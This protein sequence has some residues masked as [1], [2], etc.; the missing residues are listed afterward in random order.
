[1]L[2]NDLQTHLEHAVHRAFPEATLPVVLEYPRESAHGDYAC[3]IALQLAKSLQKNPREVA[4]TI[5]D[6]FEKP[7]FIESIELAGPGFLN[8]KV[9]STYLVREIQAILHAKETYGKNRSGEGKTVMIE[10]SS[11]N[12]N[13]PLHLGH[14]RN[15]FLGMACARLLEANGYRVIKT[16]I[17]NDRGI[18]ICKSMLAYQR[19]GNDATPEANGKKGDHFVGD[20]YVQY[21]KA[22]EEDRSLE[23]DAKTMLRRWEQGDPDIRALWRRMNDWV[24]NGF[25][26]TYGAIGSEFDQITFESDVSEGGR[27]LVEQALSEGKLERLEGGAIAIDLS[28]EGLGDL[29][30]GKKILI[31]SD[32]TTIYMTQDLQLAVQRMEGTDLDQLIYVVGNEQDY[33]FKVLFTVLERLGYEWAKQCHHLSYGMVDLPGGKMKSREGTAVDIDT[34]LEELETLVDA[35][36]DK[37]LLDYPKEERRLLIRQIAL[38]ALKYYLLKVDARSRILYDPASS[39]DFQGDTG[40]YLQ[41]THARLCSILRKAGEMEGDATLSK[42]YFQEEEALALLRKLRFFPEGVQNALDDYRLHSIAT[43]LHELAQLMNHFYAKYPVLEAPNE[44]LRKARLALVMAVAQVLRNGL[45]LLGIEPVE[46][47]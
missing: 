47:M 6:V 39:I 16:Q 44:R 41:Y 8:F 1:M 2:K 14:A 36:I 28:K 10:Y 34:L 29:E 23:D 33:H 3:T 22:L 25:Q 40:P 5:L 38:A 17:I 37:R 12:T 7:D 9:S 24:L 43:Y 45:M 42:E 18:H 21:Q 13:K 15:N 30:T 35:E 4:Q 20:F 32:G 31:R 11:P 19:F 46:R 26:E 27:A